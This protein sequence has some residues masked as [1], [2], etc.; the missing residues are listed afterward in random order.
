MSQRRRRRSARRPRGDLS[1]DNG[2]GGPTDAQWAA[3]E[4]L[5]PRGRNRDARRNGRNGSSSTGSGGGPGPAR[6][7]GTCPRPTGRGR[8]S[9][10]GPPRQR[11]GTWRK[12]LTALQGRA[13]AAGADHLG[14]VRGLHG[15]AGA[16]ARGRGTQAR[17]SAGRAAGRG[18]CRACPS[19]AGPLPRR[20]DHQGA[21][22]LR[23]GP[24]TALDGHHRGPARRQPAVPGRAG[25]HPGPPSGPGRPAPGPGGYQPTRPTVPAP[26]ALTC[27][28]ADP[29]HHPGEGRPG[30]PPQGQGPR[31]RLLT[32]LRPGRLQ[33]PPCRGMR[34]R[35]A[36]RNRA[37]ATRYDKLAV[38]YEANVCIAAINERLSPHL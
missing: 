18:R 30:S 31:R 29:L 37:V 12:I 20:A 5:L 11:N 10:P 7:G 21:P 15:G 36:K 16:P 9:W 24:E 33:G 35:P 28:G 32:R 1:G 8:R 2:T 34:H 6:H 3:L 27:G 14:R 22:G 4:P 19:R 25:G 38:R 23:A 26:T 13:D 17:R